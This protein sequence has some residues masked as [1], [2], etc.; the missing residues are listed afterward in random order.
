MQTTNSCELDNER[1]TT[2]KRVRI[3]SMVVATGLLFVG[4]SSEVTEKSESD[5]SAAVVAEVV[6]QGTKIKSQK[7][8]PMM[9]DE[10]LVLKLKEVFEISNDYDEVDTS[11]VNMENNSLVNINWNNKKDGNSI[12]ATVD[13]YGNIINYDNYAEQNIDDGDKIIIPKYNKTS[14]KKI[15][16]EVLERAL[17]DNFKNFVYDEDRSMRSGR[18]SYSMAYQ[19]NV[20]GVPVKDSVITISADLVEG[21]VYSFSYSNYDDY[22]YS[23]ESLFDKPDKTIDL[24]S[25]KDQ[26][27]E[28]NKLFLNARRITDF[29]TKSLYPE[30]SY[31]LTYETFGQEQQ[32]NA[33]TGAAEQLGDNMAIYFDG[34]LAEEANKGKEDVTLTK[35]EKE[36]LEAIKNTVS[37]EEAEKKAKEL[38]EINDNMKMTSSRLSNY[39]YSKEDFIWNMEFSDG[40]GSWLSIGLDAK[41]LSLL[42]YYSSVDSTVGNAEE[43]SKEEAE[44]IATAFVNKHNKGIMK[45][46]ELI[47]TPGVSNMSDSVSISF[48]RKLDDG[49]YLLQDNITLNVN[50]KTK[51]VNSYNKTWYKNVDLKLGDPKLSSDEAYDLIFDKYE[52]IKNYAMVK[53][54]NVIQG[55][56]LYYSNFGRNY[57]GIIVDAMSGN[58]L[59]GDGKPSS[60]NG[61][62]IY[63]DLDKSSDSKKVQKLFDYGVAY[64]GGTLRPDEKLKQEDLVRVLYQARVFN[65]YE[66]NIDIDAMYESLISEK[67]LDE[68]EVNREGLVTKKDISKYL[69]R[70]SGLEVAAEL[71]DIYKDM[72]EDSA[73]LGEYR[74]YMT[75]ATRLGFVEVE[76]DKA[77]PNKNITRDDGLMY[78]YNY[79]FQG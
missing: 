70:M 30:I 14:V 26:Y 52:F 32:I 76:N 12:Y 78:I 63:E 37:I 19:R 10:S 48:V 34:G 20:D 13:R 59:S 58:V 79:L 9:D 72:F 46:L 39:N 29:K 73:E 41:D 65:T 21:K 40:N 33:V 62:E 24:E 5:N 31:K 22:D 69:V 43:L 3:L 2:M 45:D 44:K 1:R 35:D 47:K 68:S 36:R 77:N 25:A 18:N 49:L 74:G 17:G 55:Y 11:H 4:C 56:G 60:P 8:K 42:N 66:A 51:K 7:T 53:K 54:D 50:A 28:N 71:N 23:D 75:L 64:A 15:A 27:K 61:V 57:N 6:P 67:I 16:D 38:F